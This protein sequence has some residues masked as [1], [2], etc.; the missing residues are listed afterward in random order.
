[1]VQY[2][3]WAGHAV[4]GDFGD[5]WF[6]SQSVSE[7][8]KQRAPITLTLIIGSLFL[9][10]IL[11]T[12]LGILA[13]IRG[14]IVDRFVQAAGVIGF[15]IPGFLIAFGLV[16]WLAI[17]NQIFRATGYTK[18]SEDLGEWWKSVTLPVI[19]LSFSSLAALSLQIRGS[20]R[21]TLDLDFVRTLRSR[22]LSDRRVV[23]K[24]VLRNSAGPALS[25]LGV[26]FIGLFGAAVI[27]ERIFAIQGL[28]LTAVNSA[29]TGDVPVVMGLVVFTAVMVVVVNLLVDL[30]G[31]WL[32]PK[33]R[34]S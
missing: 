34:L 25:I 27:I 7:M 4:R 32:N 16:V 28:G 1:I 29:T 17:D 19:A 18:P 2:G 22:G 6:S 8:L 9:A 12:I 33:V 24:H 13:A 11:A 3:R 5:S 30:I 15:A 10:S 21:D 14:G 23:Y 20:V 31:A 26:Q